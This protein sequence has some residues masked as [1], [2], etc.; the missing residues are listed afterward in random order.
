MLALTGDTTTPA[1]LQRELGMQRA[2]AD[3]YDVK[4]LHAIPA[5]WDE[6][7]GYQRA[8]SVFKRTE[9]DVVWGANDDIALGALKAAREA[10]LT[11]GQDILFAGLNWSSRGMEAVRNGEMTMTHGGH[12]FAGAWSIVMLRDHFFREIEGEFFV[13]VLFKMSPITGEKRRPLYRASGRRGLGQDRFQ[14]VLQERLRAQPLRLLLG[15]DSCRGGE[16]KPPRPGL[17][18]P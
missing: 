7:I 12:F 13:N 9:V 8:A 18:P 17:T 4:L 15:S 11:P 6:E 5:E 1:G 3:N 2:V 14:P 10:G 16:L